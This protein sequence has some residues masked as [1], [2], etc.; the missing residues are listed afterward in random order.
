MSARR[1]SVILGAGLVTLLLVSIGAYMAGGG[2]DRSGSGKSVVV[3]T[4]PPPVEVVEEAKDSG[5]P[6]EAGPALDAIAQK[7]VTDLAPPPS[8]KPA[9]V[10]KPTRRPVAKKKRSPRVRKNP[11]VK[12]RGRKK[13]APGDKTEDLADGFEDL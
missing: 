11:T 13:P 12:K 3:Q 5:P 1:I 7:V 6:V 9:T 8:P 2:A 10:K 4:S